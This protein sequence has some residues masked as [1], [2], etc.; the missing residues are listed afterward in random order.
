VFSR[1]IY[2]N[3]NPFHSVFCNTIFLKCIK[4]MTEEFILNRTDSN[5]VRLNFYVVFVL[6]IHSAKPAYCLLTGA[7]SECSSIFVVMLWCTETRL[8]G[9]GFCN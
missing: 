7:Q 3:I 2:E 9:I 6:Q 4:I 8:C 5:S 1:D